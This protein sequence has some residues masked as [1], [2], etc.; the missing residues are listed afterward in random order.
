MEKLMIAR[1]SGGGQCRSLSGKG[2]TLAEVLIT[3][4]IIGIVA[5]MTLPTIVQKYRNHVVET[6]L[7]KFYT[8]FNQAIRLAE[9]EYGDKKDWFIDASGVDLDEDGN[10]IEDSAK[11]DLWFKTYLSNFIV[12]NKKIDT[13]GQ[14]LYYLADGTAFQL[15]TDGNPSL[16]DILFYPGNPEKCV[17][18]LNET[19]GVCAFWFEYCPSCTGGDWKF[20]YDKGLEPGKYAWDGTL[21]DLLHDSLR[22]C[23]EVA[24]GGNYCTAFIQY[25]GWKIT[26]DYPRKVRY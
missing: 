9:A 6:R 26:K 19:R 17:G 14:I 23:A 20:L 10:P 22:G 24:Q 8:I 3:L 2:F 18:S 4:G 11:I 7:K 21:N 25:N 5:S 12:L 13:R 15:G 16:R 1:I